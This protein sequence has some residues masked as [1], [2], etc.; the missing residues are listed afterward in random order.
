M[1]PDWIR[2]FFSSHAAQLMPDRAQQILDEFLGE[3]ARKEARLRAEDG[4]I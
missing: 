2:R 1:W 4:F 3:Q